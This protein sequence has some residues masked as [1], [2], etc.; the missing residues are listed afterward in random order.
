MAKNNRDFVLPE[1]GKKG[2]L[3]RR[4][5]LM[6]TDRCTKHRPPDLLECFLYVGYIMLASTC[7]LRAYRTS[8]V[9][10]PNEPSLLL[11]LLLTFGLSCFGQPYP[12]KPH[13]AC[14]RSGGS[15]S[16]LQRLLWRR[17]AGFWLSYGNI[18]T[19]S[20]NWRRP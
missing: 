4:T 7:T 12:R 20:M 18:W 14:A 15:A 9:S 1:I 11:C 19:S 6:R 16:F 13:Q 8:T 5:S 3:Q 17:M 2:Y 10:C